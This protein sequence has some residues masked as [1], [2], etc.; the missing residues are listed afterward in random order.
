LVPFGFFSD[1]LL[2]QAVGSPHIAALYIHEL[3]KPVLLL[4]NG[5]LGYTSNARDCSRSALDRHEYGL[6]AA[7]MH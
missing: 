3:Q 7:E 1:C 2:K 6:P 4:V 5:T